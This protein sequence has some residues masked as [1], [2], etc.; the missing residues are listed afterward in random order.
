METLDDASKCPR[1][2]QSEDCNNHCGE[3]E[4]CPGK[5][6]V[7]ASCYGDGGVPDAGPPP[8]TCDE[9]QEVCGEGDPCSDPDYYCHQ[10]CCLPILF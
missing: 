4:L 9:G 5:T 3:C 10:G 1:C 8:Y 6:E 7:P 2:M